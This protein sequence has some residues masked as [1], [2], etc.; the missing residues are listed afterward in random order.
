M[1]PSNKYV[2]DLKNWN[3]TY[4]QITSDEIE[5]HDLIDSSYIEVVTN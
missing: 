2:I 5:G 3:E 4:N 1:V